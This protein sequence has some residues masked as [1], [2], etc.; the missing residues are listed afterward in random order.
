MSKSNFRSYKH[1]AIYL[2]NNMKTLIL[3]TTLV[4]ATLFTVST[5]A[6]AQY[7]WLDDKGSKQF[8]D[9][10]PPPNVPQNK[11]LKSPGL[12]LDSVVSE[13]DTDA[14]QAKKP[15]QPESIAEKEAAYKKRRD[16][17]A[18]K[19]KKASEEA[20]NTAAKAENCRRMRE[21]QQSLVSGQQF[22][23][24]DANGTSTLMTAEKRKQ[25]ISTVNQNL[26]D[27]GN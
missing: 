18:A 9:Q 6:L 21:Y 5:A 12:T 23:L 25:E 1:A 2:V 4:L 14:D 19:E 27:C 22:A 13:P 26:L 7:V 16:E 20:K 17:L 10:P 8:S 24:T 15:K 11:I 3:R